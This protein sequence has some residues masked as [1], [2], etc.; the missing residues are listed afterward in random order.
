MIDVH[1]FISD[2]YDVNCSVKFQLHSC[3]LSA[4]ETRCNV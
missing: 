3:K 2:K 1:K 4:I